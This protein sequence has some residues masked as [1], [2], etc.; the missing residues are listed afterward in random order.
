MQDLVVRNI[1][2]WGNG[3][4]AQDAGEYGVYVG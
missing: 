1:R 4:F 3:L 2:S